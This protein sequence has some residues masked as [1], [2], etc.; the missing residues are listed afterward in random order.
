MTSGGVRYLSLFPK[1]T[2]DVVTGIRVFVSVR[3]ARKEKTEFEIGT[4]KPDA[5]DEEFIEKFGDGM[6]RLEAVSMTGSKKSPQ[7]LETL[8]KAV[9]VGRP[10][11]WL[12]GVKQAMRNSGLELDEEDD[13]EADEEDR[14]GFD[15][16]DHRR[17]FGHDDR[18]SPRDRGMLPLDHGFGGGMGSAGGP[19][20]V[21]VSKNST[22]PVAQGLDPA[23]Q[24]EILD[25]ARKEDREDAK[26][27]TMMNIIMQ[28]MQQQS[29]A[30]AREVESLRQIVASRATSGQEQDSSTIVA[31]LR[32]ELEDVS[33]RLRK[34]RAEADDDM[35][36]M[37]SS[38]DDMERRY[39]SRIDELEQEN[40][41]LRDELVS[42]RGEVQKGKI[43][44]EV[45]K[46]MASSGLSKEASQ[47]VGAKIKSI[48]EIA[49]PVLMPLLSQFLSAMSSGGAGGV[50]PPSMG[51]GTTGGALPG[52]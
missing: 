4:I 7:V 35:R 41:K 43:E 32:R 44:V 11:T 21:Q 22:V 28:M 23:R 26:E 16:D 40:R 27:L 36:R 20:V 42:A 51:G 17:G 49:G 50:A 46:L 1:L 13:G 38:M 25:Q 33:D 30:A 9:S 14:R 34:V 12:K 19:F 24:Q 29:Q 31:G 47:D 8:E 48:M 37:R 18:L 15:P 5:T 10:P 52:T 6:Y 45:Q 39:R 3:D 2:E